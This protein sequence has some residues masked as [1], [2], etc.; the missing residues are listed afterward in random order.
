MSIYFSQSL[1]YNVLR[2]DLGSLKN[3]VDQ[4]TK[5]VSAIVAKAISPETTIPASFIPSDGPTSVALTP[6]TSSRA[7]SVTP[8]SSSSSELDVSDTGSTNSFRVRNWLTSVRSMPPSDSE[9]SESLS[10]QINP[11][12]SFSNP[13][14]PSPTTELL[15]SDEVRSVIS[16]STSRRN[17]ATN[18]TRILFD[19]RTRITSNVSGR[20]KKQLN[21]AIMSQI[22]FLTF[23]HYPCLPGEVE[24][25]Q[26][27]ICVISIDEASRRLRNK[28][29]K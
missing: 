17:F 13:P 9:T 26:W 19:E 23:K 27:K 6:S 5:S 11:S 21:P 24:S 14:A 2:K 29:K 28:P 25:D 10:N 3:S 8:I 16:R 18:L 1:K 7:S 12:R 20:C 22:K 4:L 15:T